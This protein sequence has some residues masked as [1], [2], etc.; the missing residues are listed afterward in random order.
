MVYGMPS[1]GLGD[2]PQ[3]HLFKVRCSS[4]GVIGSWWKG[5]LG[6][7]TFGIHGGLEKVLLL[8]VV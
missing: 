3:R 8:V 5:A 6:V 4:A 2:D 1:S 7:G